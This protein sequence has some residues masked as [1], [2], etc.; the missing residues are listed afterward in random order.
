MASQIQKN[1]ALEKAVELTAKALQANDKVN[2][3]D[4]PEDVAAFL[5]AIYAKLV[6][7]QEGE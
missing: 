3:I 2:Q 6:E 4:F 7:L 5:E 1:F